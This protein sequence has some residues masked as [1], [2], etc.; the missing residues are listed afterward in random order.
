MESLFQTASSFRYLQLLVPVG[1]ERRESH[2]VVASVSRAPHQLRHRCMRTTHA[3]AFRSFFV[4][5]IRDSGLSA[6]RVDQ[7]RP[8]TQR[9]GAT[10]RCALGTKQD[11]LRS[12]AW[13]LNF[14]CG[15]DWA[16][17]TKHRDNPPNTEARLARFSFQLK[18][19]PLRS[20]FC[21]ITGVIS[22]AGY[23]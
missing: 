10:N 7:F 22:D 23:L 6:I 11:A 2:G 19:S 4:A 8:R 21:P 15:C 9:T 12:Q 1:I 3:A 14:I 16:S 20:N 13:F 5:Q 17:A 18:E